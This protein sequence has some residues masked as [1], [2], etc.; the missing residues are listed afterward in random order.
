MHLLLLDDRREGHYPFPEDSQ[1]FGLRVPFLHSINHPQILFIQ[2]PTEHPQPGE[3]GQS[4]HTLT[5][6]L[7]S[8]GLNLDAFWETP[9]D[10]QHLQVW[11]VVQGLKEISVPILCDLVIR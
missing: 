10:V 6:S 4:G 11:Q 1:A 2:E 9:A 8:G 3:A 5:Q 7:D